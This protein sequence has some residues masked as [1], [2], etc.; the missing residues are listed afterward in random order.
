MM[1][2]YSV[3]GLWHSLR[4]ILSINSDSASVTRE[5]A[6]FASRASVKYLE[7]QKQGAT[8]F[9]WTYPFLKTSLNNDVVDKVLALSQPRWQT[10]EDY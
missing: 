9:V 10:K 3:D 6:C 7:A 1:Y 5:Q 8:I 2:T 4:L